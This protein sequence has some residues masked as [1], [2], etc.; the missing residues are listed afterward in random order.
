VLLHSDIELV[1]GIRPGLFLHS[2]QIRPAA[3]VF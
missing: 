2:G 3:L 1:L